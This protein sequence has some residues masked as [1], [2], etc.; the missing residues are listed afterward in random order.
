VKELYITGNPALDDVV[1]GYQERWAEYRYNPSEITGLFKST[2]T[3]TLDAWHYAQR[4]TSPVLNSTFISD[5]TDTIL[6]RNL[7]VGAEASGQQLIMDGFMD[8]RWA[9]PLPMYSVPGLIDHF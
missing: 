5:Q 8:M 3:G 7:A 4:F 9:R 1:F 2:T 6:T